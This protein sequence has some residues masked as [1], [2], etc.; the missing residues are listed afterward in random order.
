MKIIFILHDTFP[1]NVGGTE[2]YVYNLARALIKGGHEAI[3]CSATSA[4]DHKKYAISRQI[5]NGVPIITIFHQA[6]DLLHGV[7]CL[8]LLNGLGSVY[9]DEKIEQAIATILD[10]VKPDIVHIHHLVN[11]SVGIIDVIKRRNIPIVTTIHDYWYLCFNGQL[12]RNGF[13]AHLPAQCDYSCVLPIE[14]I[15]DKRRSLFTFFS[16]QS[17]FR[18][19]F[20]KY[21]LKQIGYHYFSYYIFLRKGFFSSQ[22]SI[23]RA[24]ILDALGRTDL[25]IAPSNFLRRLYIESGVSS[26]K[27]I[28]LAH[29]FDRTG[30][31]DIKK[32][33]KISKGIN[34]GFVGRITPEKGV[35]VLLE[36]FNC[37][38]QG[39]RLLVFGQFD[40]QGNNYHKYLASTAHT[41]Q[42]II[43]N[44]KFEPPDVP[45]IFK[46]ID[47]LIV[48]SLWWENAPMVIHEA[49]M[50]KVPVI[51][52]DA[53][54]MKE[55]VHHMENGLLF[56]MGDSLD[57]KEKM[58][59]IIND[60]SLLVRLSAGIPPV[61]DIKEHA[62]ELLEIYS[63]LVKNH[64]HE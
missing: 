55:F 58:E 5:Y 30:F 49:F 59:M 42:S 26:R 6:Y 38:K 13:E 29:G 50:A 40:P 44:G 43:F 2:V 39:S 51:A 35:H 25:L 3:I 8:R 9:C 31:T 10:T 17:F 28:Y 27:I 57:L 11:L 15:G 1:F 16:F 32:E 7:K 64:G 62:N 4:N 34:F 22:I 12:L 52:S 21:F 37:L 53:G 14:T 63:S 24:R 45:K 18:F 60:P 41:N 33:K 56:R 23:R 54:A 48:P 46:E 19:W 61:K 36:A 20:R 47:I